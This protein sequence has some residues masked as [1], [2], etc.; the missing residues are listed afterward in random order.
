MT[1]NEREQQFKTELKELLAKYGASI[2]YEE[3]DGDDEP[4]GYTIWDLYVEG[5]GFWLSLKDIARRS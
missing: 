5:P 2:Y 1:N 3:N 4:L